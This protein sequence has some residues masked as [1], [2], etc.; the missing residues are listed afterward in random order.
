MANRKFKFNEIFQLDLEEVK[1]D[2]A[3]LSDSE[4]DS[5]PDRK[6]IA[7]ATS[8]SQAQPIEIKQQEQKEQ[9]QMQ[10]Q[11]FPDRSMPIEI[12]PK[13]V[14]EKKEEKEQLEQHEHAL[15]RKFIENWKSRNRD[16]HH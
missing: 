12:N 15:L 16:N 2:E 13:A 7:V 1:P 3:E 8:M 10:Q 9:L 6:S 11:S 5:E 14:K 4:S